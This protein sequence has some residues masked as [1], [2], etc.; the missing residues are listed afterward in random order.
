MSPSSRIWIGGLFVV[1]S[2][3]AHFGLPNLYMLTQGTIFLLGLLGLI[4]VAGG[5]FGL[6]TGER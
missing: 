5:V 3:L 2:L 4:L 6:A 1:S